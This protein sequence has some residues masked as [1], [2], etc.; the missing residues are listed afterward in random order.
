MLAFCPA[1]TAYPD[2]WISLPFLIVR[3]P[4]PLNIKITA[5]APR[6][7]SGLQLIPK[8]NILNMAVRERTG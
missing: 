1:T 4:W 5:T 3:T 6:H 2:N 8:T 7:E